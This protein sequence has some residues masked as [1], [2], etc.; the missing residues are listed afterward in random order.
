MNAVIT[1]STHGNTAGRENERY[2]D[3]CLCFVLQNG[4][5]SR[6]SRDGTERIKNSRDDSRM[7]SRL[8]TKGQNEKR[9]QMFAIPEKQRGD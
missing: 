2:P 4:R 5:K 6:R 1:E 8:I 9:T 7:N 3:H